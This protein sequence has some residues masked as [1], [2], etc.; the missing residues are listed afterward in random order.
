MKLY[1]NKVTGVLGATAGA[2]TNVAKLTAKRFQDVDVEIVPTAEDGSASSFAPGSTG[3]LVVKAENDFSGAAKLLDAAWDT[4]E[5]TG[6]GY[7]FSF[8]AASQGI[9]A[10]LGTEASKT[11][12]LEMVIS[13][14]GK[15]LVLPT[16]QLVLENNYYREGEAIPEDPE[17]PYPLPGEIV[18]SGQLATQA[19]AEAGTANGKWMSPL[20]V[21]QAVAAWVGANVS[22]AWEA[23]S[24]KPDTFPPSEHGHAMADVDGLQTALGGKQ[25]AGD[26]V[27]EAPSD[28]KQYARKDGAWVVGGGGGSAY[29]PSY[30]LKSAS[31]TAEAGKAYAIDTTSASLE[32]TLP[33]TPAGGDVIALADARGTWATN[34]VVVLRNG[35]KIEGSEVDFTNNA[36]GTFFSLVYIDSTTGWRVLASG[37]KPLNL[38]APTITGEY[39]FT[40]TN[41]TWTGSPTSYAYQWQVSDDGLAGW[42]DIEGA[43]SSTYLAPEAQEGKYVRLGVVATNSNGPSVEVFSDASAAIALPDF[44]MT[45]LLAFWKLSDLTDASGNGHTLTNNNGV[46]FGA[47]KIGDAAEFTSTETLSVNY[48]LPSASSDWTVAAWLYPTSTNGYGGSFPVGGD[49]LAG[50]WCVAFDD[51]SKL[52]FANGGYAADP[53]TTVSL[54]AWHHVV[55]VKSNGVIE[56][57]VDGVSA[58]TQTWGGWLDASVTRINAEFGDQCFHGKIDAV[59]MWN[60][61]L[62]AQEVAQL[63]NA[64]SGVEPA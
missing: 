61:A 63:Y 54:N 60:R 18:T 45:G 29:S 59:G 37:T 3:L 20:R 53:G 41:G 46:T 56:V 49:N 42:A 31:F 7:V 43:T 8:L 1:Y 27:A 57:W 21:A 12:A 26:Y 58:G 16:L 52:G 39:D 9:D 51:S 15:R 6:R 13:E 23:I 34:P 38:T 35:G 2:T 55:G 33:A 44:P 5:E 48:G 28:G 30:E 32:V 24:G 36:A 19:E 14:G 40:S 4:P 62:T 22:L 50:V 11:F 17:V 10:A 47:G 25:P 64:G